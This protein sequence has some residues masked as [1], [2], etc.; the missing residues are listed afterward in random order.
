MRRFPTRRFEKIAA[1]TAYSHHIFRIAHINSFRRTAF[2]FTPSHL[3]GCASPGAPL[4]MCEWRNYYYGACQHGEAVLHSYC[5]HS[6]PVTAQETGKKKEQRRDPSSTDQQ[7]TSGPHEGGASDSN[8]KPGQA[9]SENAGTSTS[10]L[11]PASKD[12]TPHRT[13]SSSFFATTSVQHSVTPIPEE[14]ADDI[15]S[16]QHQQKPLTSPRRHSESTAES[17]A[18]LAPFGK[19]TFRK[20]MGGGSSP[21]PAN[22]VI[23]TKNHNDREEM[24]NL[25]YCHRDTQC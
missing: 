25:T 12:S 14:T 23:T 20:L 19:S 4:T 1:S 6:R 22:P 24:V 3:W 9:G 8:N 10:S 11:H 21:Q 7:G 16:L 13:A 18:G 15:A 5:E 2:Q 17:M